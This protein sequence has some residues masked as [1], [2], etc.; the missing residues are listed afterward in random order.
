LKCNKKIKLIPECR[1]NDIPI[2]PCP[3]KGARKREIISEFIN[4][5]IVKKM[6]RIKLSEL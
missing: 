6:I 3:P 4:Y 1:E 5:E 2:A